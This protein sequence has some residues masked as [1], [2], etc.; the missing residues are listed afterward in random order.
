[1]GTNSEEHLGSEVIYQEIV[2]NEVN[3]THSIPVEPIHR[4]I[5]E[6]IKSN[7]MVIKKRHAVIPPHII[8]EAISMIRELDLR[9]SGPITQKEME[10]VEQYALAKY[11]EY[12]GLI[13]GDG[14]G[15]DLSSFIINEEPSE[16]MSDNDRRKSPRGTPRESSG[17][18]FGGN[19]PE[20]DRTQLEPS[21]LQDILNKKSSFPGSFISIPEIQAHNK[22]L[23]QFGLPDDEYLV[24]FTTS[25]KDAMMLVGESYP[26][27]KGNYYMTILG[28]Q[29]EDYIKEFASFK[30]SK[31]IHAPKTWLDLRIRGSQLSQNFRR[32][33]KINP[34][35]LFA[36]PADVNGTM[37][38]V[39]EAHRNCW[40]V[41]LDA[42]ALVVGKDNLKLALHR[43]DFV[44]S[45]VD[46]N[47][48]NASRI[49]CL[50]VRKKSFDT[51]STASSLANE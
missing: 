34:K 47:H 27:V 11:P 30:E 38:W 32:K 26:F 10:Y 31:V 24:L 39:S 3:G 48:S 2:E 9:W 20:M 33:C 36:Y 16:P 42:S 12:A 46:N 35:G 40:H 49:T 15:I 25:Y 1:M 7:S 4:L 18:L 14:N 43:P 5:T 45:S 37:H 19:L 22:V 41:L 51:S 6:N 44:V 23:K 13:Q 21:R 8:A 17:Y 29:E 50:L 28:E